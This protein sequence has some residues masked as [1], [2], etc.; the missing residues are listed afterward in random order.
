MKTRIALAICL[1]LAAVS[2]LRTL[3]A[4]SDPVKTNDGQGIRRH[5]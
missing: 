5:A 2:P 3:A 1:A 4:I